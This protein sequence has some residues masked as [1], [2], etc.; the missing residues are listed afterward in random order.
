MNLRAELHERIASP[1]PRLVEGGASFAYTAGTILSFLL[2]F[3]AL[4]GVALAAFYSPST[5]S[6]WASVAYLQDQAALGWLV[7]GVHHYGG[8]AI[9][10]VAGVHLVQTA[11]A[12]A[13]K[14]PREM[15]WW[16]GLLLMGIVLGFSLTGY[17]L[18]WDQKGYWATRVATNIT[19]TV[20]LVAQ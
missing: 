13:Y 10:I 20:P 12:G 1:P 18:P 3:E 2:A 17:L 9:V 16:F 14:R 4:T 8:G 5:S 19:G 11:L 6:A 7:R 15:N